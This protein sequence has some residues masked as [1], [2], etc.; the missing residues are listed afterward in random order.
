MRPMQLNPR[1][2]TISHQPRGIHKLP[3]HRLNIPLR[4][5]ARIRE[6]NHADEL[7]KVAIAQTHGDGTRRNSRPE[8]AALTCDA[9]RLSAGVDDLH[10]GGRAVLLAGGGVFAPCC[11]EVGVV[12]FARVVV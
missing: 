9:Q 8:D 12:F 1:K 11:D 3:R 6:G 5:L 7:L 10:D 2:P 4:H